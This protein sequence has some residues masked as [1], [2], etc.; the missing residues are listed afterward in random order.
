MSTT[1]EKDM[2]VAVETGRRA[3]TLPEAYAFADGC[4]HRDTQIAAF[5]R[6]KADAFGPRNYSA[7]VLLRLMAD[8]IERG[9]HVY[10]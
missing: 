7:A 3:R 2:S 10:G 1:R 6:A 5:L 4:A 8:E 9:E